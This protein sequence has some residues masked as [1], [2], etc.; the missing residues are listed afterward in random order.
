MLNFSLKCLAISNSLICTAGTRGERSTEGA[1]WRVHRRNRAWHMFPFST[2]QTLRH[3]GGDGH[4]E[5]QGIL[6]IFKIVQVRQDGHDAWF[7]EFAQV[8]HWSHTRFH[9]ELSTHEWNTGSCQLPVDQP[10]PISLRGQGYFDASSAFGYSSECVCVMRVFKVANNI[11]RSI[12]LTAA[13]IPATMTI[14]LT[15]ELRI[16][17][18]YGH[19]L[20]L[21]YFFEYF[22]DKTHRWTPQMHPKLTRAMLELQLH[23]WI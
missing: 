18:S 19:R 9:S 21:C 17:A 22:R 20:L 13:F 3:R 8:K 6:K 23:L 11:D 15:R 5:P 1:H 12:Y 7:V 2:W 10:P 16:L 4:L 14:G